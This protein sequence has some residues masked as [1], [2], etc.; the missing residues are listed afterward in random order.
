MRSSKS[1]TSIDSVAGAPAGPSPSVCVA[2]ALEVRHGT[3]GDRCALSSA[4]RRAIATRGGGATAE[5]VGFRQTR[6]DGGVSSSSSHS[7][8]TRGTVLIVEDD[9]D[10]R[11]IFRMWLRAAGYDVHEAADGVDAL[12][13][14]EQAPPGLVVL[15]L[16]LPTLD[17]VSVYEELASNVQTRDIPVV[18]VTGSVDV[19]LDRLP[20][21]CILRKPVT[22][23]ELLAAVRAC[24][25]A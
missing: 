22:P 15:D 14:V 20:A 5:I 19:N 1:W 17:G 25:G 7:P 10:L 6:Y 9:Q 18:V 3:A 11:T 23:E 13:I 16:G 24:L 4:G 2:V 21:A 8:V 12:R